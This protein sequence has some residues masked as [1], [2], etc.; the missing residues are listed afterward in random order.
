MAPP[1]TRWYMYAVGVPGTCDAS[2]PNFFDQFRAT[3]QQ[4]FAAKFKI[5][6]GR[7]FL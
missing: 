1:L 4:K 7:A 2:N 6:K 3:F 5:S